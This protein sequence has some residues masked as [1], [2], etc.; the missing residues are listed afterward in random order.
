MERAFELAKSGDCSSV[1]EIKK[2]LK[3]ER[4]SLEQITGR[5]LSKQLGALIV[6]NG[7]GDKPTV[8]D[9]SASR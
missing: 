6:Q 5:S 9:E 4:Y 2:R 8:N 7:G 1:A 3:A